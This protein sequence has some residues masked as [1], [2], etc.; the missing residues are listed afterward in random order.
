MGLIRKTLHGRITIRGIGMKHN[1]IS[2][3]IVGVIFLS[4]LFIGVGKTESSDR[5]VYY[6]KTDDGTFFY[7]KNSITKV[8]PK[9]IRVLNKLKYSKIGKDE[10]VQ[11]RKKFN[12]SI[13]GWEKLDNR[14]LYDEL[15]CKNNT[16]KTMKSVVYNDEG[17]ILENLVNPNPKGP[18]VHGVSGSITEL[19]LRKV[20]PN[21][22]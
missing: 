10:M 11:V 6:G 18:I 17:N 19:L 16:S 15:D 2:F 1:K 12:M 5:W 9:V 4:L 14:I 13:D 7:D 22:E 3:V 21:S 8:G 20:C